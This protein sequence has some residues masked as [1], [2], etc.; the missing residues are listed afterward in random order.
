MQTGRH[1]TA[2]NVAASELDLAIDPRLQQGAAQFAGAADLAFEMLYAFDEGL[3]QGQVQ[4]LQLKAPGQRLTRIARIQPGLDIKL[5]EVSTG[6]LH[7]GIHLLRLQGAGDIEALIAE[8]L[9]LTGGVAQ[10]E[11]TA[12]G[13]QAYLAIGPSLG[14]AQVDVAVE[15]ALP[16]Q[17]RWQQGLQTGQ[18][19]G[20]QVPGET[21]IGQQLLIV[22]TE[23]GRAGAPAVATQLQTT[24]VQA[25]D[26]GRTLQGPVLAAGR[27]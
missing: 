5:P 12:P 23:A 18:R 24:T 9:P 17:F 6:Q 14:Q 22:A 3:A 2:A 26:A 4:P 19:E 20:T 25:L 8:G 1:A 27:D 11:A 10:L 13:L 15:G 21:G 7:L 16:G